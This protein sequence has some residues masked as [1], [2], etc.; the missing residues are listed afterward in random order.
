[1]ASFD[2]VVIGSGPGG[3]VCAIRAA[4]LGL[5]V[6]VVEKDKG[7][8]GTC[9]NVGCIPSKA[10][11][12]SSELYHASLH[13]FETHGIKTGSV[14]FDL[15]KMM[16][17][18]DKIVTQSNQGI[19][20][21][22]KK[23]KV[24][25]Y[26]GF[27]KVLKPGL[28]EVAGADG[29]K[30]QLET[31]N[32]V[33]ATGSTV[34]ELPFLKYDEKK[35]VSSTGALALEKVPK[36]MVVVGGGVIG[37]ELGSVWM[38]LGSKVTVI[39]FA[40]RLCPVMDAS[41]MATLQK[42]LTKQGMKF[43]FKTKVTASKTKGDQV[44]LEF[45]NMAD[46]SKGQITADVVLVSTGRKPFSE[47]LGLEGA[48]VQKDQR[49]FVTVDK[50]FQTNVPGIFAI[51]DLTPGPMLAHKA[52]EEGVALAEILAGQAGHIN[53]ET[54]PS[55]IYTYPEVASVG[56]TE[57]QV[58]E[59]GIPFA[60][61]SFPFM[62]NGRARALG[63]TEGQVKIITDKRSDRIIGGHIVGPR[64]SELLGEIVVAMEFGGS[65]EDLA[66]SFHAHP[67]LN[68]VIREAALAVDKR[69]RQI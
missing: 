13:D 5:K 63:F 38:R 20:F 8:G 15:K 27:G 11:L 57:E 7:L 21:L 47:G 40:D 59:S 4:Q 9:T 41:S 3:Y 43:L 30:T 22:F 48:G 34:V 25:S 52:E 58:K 12:E 35:I 46:N 36:E 14:E 49:G 53:Y 2:L 28:V 18:K 31:K 37:L 29:Q 60:V 67:T 65:S 39:E 61:G 26:N 1:M 55:V 56:L 23:N 24:E 64:A 17:R 54:V 44:E 32:I 51:G 66:R 69:A 42:I 62:A 68:E 16:A 50:H 19:A 45:E 33:L 6:A 10:L